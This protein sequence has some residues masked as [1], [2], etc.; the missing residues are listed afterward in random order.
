MSKISFLLQ[1]HHRF[2]VKITKINKNVITKWS[3]F[4]KKA[5]KKSEQKEKFC[6]VY[7]KVDYCESGNSGEFKRENGWFVFV[8]HE[9]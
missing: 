2:Q 9:A 1:Y 4:G 8:K 5:E 6:K 3:D 7:F